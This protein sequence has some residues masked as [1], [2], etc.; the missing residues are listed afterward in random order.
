MQEVIA[1]VGYDPYPEP[2]S[3]AEELVS[4]RRLRGLRV[5]DAASL[6]D[7]DPATWSSWERNEHQITPRYLDRIRTLLGDVPDSGGCLSPRR[8]RIA[9]P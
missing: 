5:R 4:F 8:A 7:V 3:L 2:S 9:P 6:A 1:F